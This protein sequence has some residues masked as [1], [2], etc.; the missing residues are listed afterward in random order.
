M[1]STVGI[2]FI[3]SLCWSLPTAVVIKCVSEEKKSVLIRKI[4]LCRQ[5]N[6]MTLYLFIQQY[7][8]LKVELVS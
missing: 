7:K 3:T 4:V 1:V 5:S 8:I 6:M 2:S